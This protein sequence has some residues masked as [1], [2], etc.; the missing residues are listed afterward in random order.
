LA[1]VA[2][3]AVVEVPRAVVAVLLVLLPVLLQAAEE[4]AHL[5]HKLLP[6]VL[7]L[8][9]AVVLAPRRVALRPEPEVAALLLVRGLVASQSLRSR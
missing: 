5:A 2:A 4:R 7:L 9:V 8:Q 6:L 3:V 1:A